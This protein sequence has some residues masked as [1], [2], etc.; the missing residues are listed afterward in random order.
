MLRYAG[1][2]IV[3]AIV[4]G[5]IVYAIRNRRAGGFVYVQ[6]RPAVDHG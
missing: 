6:F 2:A 3:Y 4:L 5:A 1:Y